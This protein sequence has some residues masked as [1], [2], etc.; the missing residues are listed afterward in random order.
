MERPPND[1]KEPP[2]NRRNA[3]RILA[4]GGIFAMASILAFQLEYW[5]A[6]AQG[7]AVENAIEQA[8]TV[9]FCTMVFSQLLYAFSA[10]SETQTIRRIGIFTN[11]KLVLAVGA[12]AL[13]QLAVIYL[14]GLSD[15][16]HTYSLGL[17]EWTIVLPMSLFALLFNE[18]WKMFAI[19]QL[20][21]AL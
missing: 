16:F 6:M 7:A 19:R 14:P 9:A 1:P 18:L 5:A 12:S 13:L 4:V 17:E 8:R 3:I 2:V 21:S 11:P 20:R 10:R 15:V